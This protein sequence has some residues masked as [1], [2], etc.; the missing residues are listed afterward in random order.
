MGWS[1]EWRRFVN[2]NLWEKIVDFAMTFCKEMHATVIF[3]GFILEH[4]SKA[5]PLDKY[6]VPTMDRLGFV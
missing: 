1:V 6:Y 3:Y 4:V 2:L 5:H